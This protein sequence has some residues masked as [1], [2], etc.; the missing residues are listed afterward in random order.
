LL[1][2]GPVLLTLGEAP[3]RPTTPA[4]NPSDAATEAVALTSFSLVIL[5]PSYILLFSSG[6]SPDVIALCDALTSIDQIV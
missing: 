2:C 5:P 4:I 3:A 1:D 6:C